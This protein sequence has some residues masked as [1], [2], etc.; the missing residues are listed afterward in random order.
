MKAT[1]MALLQQIRSARKGIPEAA[2]ALGR[3]S[4]SSAV[5]V[6]A[7]LLL[8]ACGQRAQPSPRL[9]LGATH[10]LDDSGLLDTLV[11]AFRAA[12]PEQDLQ[13]MLGG[14]GEVLELGRRGDV[15]VLLTH[16]PADEEAFVREGW[17]MDR[18]SVM[19]NDFVL[20]GP[21][22]DP[23]A[24]G[25][26][27]TVGDAFRRLAAARAPFVSRGDDSGTHQKERQIWRSIGVSPDWPGYLEAGV[28]MADALRLAGERGA[29]VLTDRA[30]F[31]SL[32]RELPI[33]VVFEGDPILRNQYSVMV[34]R[35]PR[36]PAGAT[37]FIE[38]ITS[39]G[40]RAL[41]A[42]YGRERFG[43]Q[44]FLPD[45]ADPPE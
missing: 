34:V 27:A 1:R 32:R 43:A 40:A 17:G 3:L 39:P 11:L 12:H 7:S 38:W 24:A 42:N 28:G 8:A 23:A 15:D 30:T 5:M 33:G 29:Y 22:S 19:H 4:R 9:I 21:A 44:V 36:E 37:A 2:A 26:A 41:I 20:L 35:N 6:L 10:T 13:V 18:H 16:A 25:M 14:S 31:M 45:S